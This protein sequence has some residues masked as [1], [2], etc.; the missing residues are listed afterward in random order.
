MQ[1]IKIIKGTLEGNINYFN[2][3]YQ[4][5]LFYNINPCTVFN[6]LTKK[7]NHSSKLPALTL[8]YISTDTDETN[9][10]I[11][12]QPDARTGRTKYTIEEKKE[13]LRVRARKQY[14]RTKNKKINLQNAQL[15]TEKVQ[16]EPKI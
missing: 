3:K 6:M 5:G 8:Q 7:N 12:K 15:E 13:I 4:C 1:D 10:I 14:Q 16:D 11:E 2:S 9:I